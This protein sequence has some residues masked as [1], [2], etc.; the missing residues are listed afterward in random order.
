MTKRRSIQGYL[1]MGKPR[2]PPLPTNILMTDRVSGTVYHLTYTGSLGTL[3]LSLST[4]PVPRQFLTFGPHAGPY[5]NGRVRLFISGGALSAEEVGGGDLP[6]YNMRVMC[7]RGNS[8]LV[9]EITAS[10]NWKTGD[11]LTYTEV[12]L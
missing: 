12:Q 9:L 5:L 6:V 10:N 4:T 2:I 7:R 3:A 11:A 1:D 8:S